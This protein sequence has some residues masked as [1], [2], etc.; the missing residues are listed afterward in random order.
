MIGEPYIKSSYAFNDIETLPKILN[1][2]GYSTSFFHGA[3]NGSQNFDQ[4]TKIAGIDKYYGKNEYPEPEHDDGCWGIFD[5]EYLQYF[6]KQLTK[7]RQP[8]FSTVFTL[9]SHNPFIIPKKYK[10][11]FKKGTTNFFRSI[12]YSDYALAN[13]FKYA[14]K[15]NWYKNTIFILTADHTSSSKPTSHKSILDKYAIPIIFFDPLNSSLKGTSDK[16]IQQIDI[17]PSVL[18]YLN[19][20]ESFNSYGFSY[21]SKN[22]MI[23]NLINGNYH[24]IIDSNY[25]VFNGKKIIEFYKHNSD[26]SLKNNILK[27]INVNT[28]KEIELKIKAYLQSFNQNIIDNT[29]IDKI[30]K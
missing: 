14:K 13:F 2:K 28:I 26:K 5:E 6:G 7:E 3:I 15:E 24:V 4:Y 17:L 11:K 8:F 21:Q 30:T 10:G 18:N 27:T 19:Y 23:I 1:R 12:G 22:N 16:N 9:S 20:N 29:M 25:C